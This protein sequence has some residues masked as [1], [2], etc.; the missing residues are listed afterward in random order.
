[1]NDKKRS[2]LKYFLMTALL[3]FT[4]ACSQHKIVFDKNSVHADS[5]TVGTAGLSGSVNWIKNRKTH[6]VIDVTLENHY[7]FP[8][9][10][11]QDG[12]KLT[13]DG[14]AGTVRG[15]SLAD[16]LAPGATETQLLTFDFFGAK[17]LDGEALF[18]LSGIYTDDHDHKILPLTMKFNASAK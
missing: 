7:A 10:F 18:I 8:I 9:H 14:M 4:G 13:V 15:K 5:E 11:T 2:T 16:T 17:S 12:W 6:L 1:M 3:A